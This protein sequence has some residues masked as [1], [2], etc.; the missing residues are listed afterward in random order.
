VVVVDVDAS[1]ND[2]MVTLGK[3]RELRV[4]GEDTE[5]FGEEGNEFGAKLGASVAQF[6]EIEDVDIVVVMVVGETKEGDETDE[7]NVN[8][9]VDDV[10]EVE[11]CES[12]TTAST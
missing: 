8:V 3:M 7:V 10:G 11:P 12:R 5:I 4:V 6:G 2:S 9:D 1:E